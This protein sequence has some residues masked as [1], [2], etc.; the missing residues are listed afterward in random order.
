MRAVLRIASTESEVEGDIYCP[1]L[2]TGVGAVIPNNAAVM[3]AEAYR[4]WKRSVEKDFKKQH[5]K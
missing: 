4:D 5:E 3:M 1:G 2:A